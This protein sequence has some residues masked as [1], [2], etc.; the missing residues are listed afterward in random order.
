MIYCVSKLFVIVMDSIYSKI[1]IIIEFQADVSSAYL[2]K[3]TW[4]FKNYIKYNFKISKVKL[5]I[6]VM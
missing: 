3:I 1:F 6:L 2:L 5:L 4:M